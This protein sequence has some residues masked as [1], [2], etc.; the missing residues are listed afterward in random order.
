MTSRIVLDASAI[1]ALVQHEPGGAAVSDALLDPDMDVLVSCVNLCEAATKLVG[2]GQ[3]SSEIRLTLG[4]FLQYVVNFDAEQAIYAGDL[5]RVT[6]RFGL[7]LGDRA[8]LALA[9]SRGATAWTT[10]ADWKKL[11]LDVK[12]RLLRG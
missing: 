3:T 11:K 6:K 2:T 1:L 7:S 9:A 5:V 12:V 10:D 8:C 4:P